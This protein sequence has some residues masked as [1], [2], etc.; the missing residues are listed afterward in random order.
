MSTKYYDILMQDCKTTKDGSISRAMRVASSSSV[1]GAYG[2]MKYSS[3][4]H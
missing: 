3:Y 1:E 2:T 4:Y